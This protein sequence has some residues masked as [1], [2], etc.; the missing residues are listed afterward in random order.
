MKA[1][2]VV[3]IILIAGAGSMIAYLLSQIGGLRHIQQCIAEYL[4]TQN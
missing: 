2:H 3:T 4:A 1:E